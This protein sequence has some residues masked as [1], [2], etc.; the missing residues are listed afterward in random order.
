MDKS[1]AIDAL[2]A[3]A[4]ATRLE[5]FRLLV[6][7]APGGVPA[8]E[9]ARLVAVPHNSLSTHLAVLSRAGL[10]TLRRDGRSVIYSADLDGFRRLVGFLA[11]DCCDG[12][13][14]ICGPLV[15]DLVPCCAPATGDGTRTDA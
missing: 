9:I 2:A 14:E 5:V 11:N 15:G 1:S 12:R 4:Q 10:A 6:R 7:R 13:P 3:L 8:G